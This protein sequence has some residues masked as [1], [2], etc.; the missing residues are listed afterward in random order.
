MSKKTLEKK[1]KRK[2]EPEQW[3]VTISPKDGTSE[4]HTT[5]DLND[6]HDEMQR[7]LDKGWSVSIT[8]L[9]GI[10]LEEIKSP[11]KKQ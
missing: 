5:D 3:I 4:L 10:T 11:K 8:R 2:K 9:E 7:A 6:M 1:A